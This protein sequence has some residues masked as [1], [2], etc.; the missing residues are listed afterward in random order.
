MVPFKIVEGTNGAAF[1]EARGRKYS[2]SEIGAFTLMK[3]KE[4]AE[5]YLG[6]KVASAVIT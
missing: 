3:M 2:P 6:K 4:T 5:S 1:I